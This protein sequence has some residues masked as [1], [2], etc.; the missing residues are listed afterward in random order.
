MFEQTIEKA[1]Q[2]KAE[3]DRKEIQPEDLTT[4][5]SHVVAAIT[6][7]L[8]PKIGD[9]VY[10]CLKP[11]T[12]QLNEIATKQQQTMYSLQAIEKQLASLI[13]Q[14][15][16]LENA[17]KENYHLSEQ[18]YLERII[19]PMIRLLFPAF[20]A[21]YDA[22]R[23][24]RKTGLTVERVA[25]GTLEQV[26]VH[27]KQFLL[28]YQIEPVKH[29]PGAEFDPRIMKPLKFV[30]TN[31]KEQNSRIAECLQIGFRQGKQR[32]MR[33]EGVSIFEYRPYEAG[34]VT[35]KKGDNHVNSD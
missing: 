33:Y 6:N 9:R 28:I 22:K 13:T 16:L 29:K 4:A 27:L 7:Q 18:H 25:N 26:C 2:G 17:S 32:I 11:L 5:L 12:S 21:I 15:K 31:K 34:S 24:G 35:D 8:V 1:N 14:N 30:P 19:E 20:D 3:T 23:R 10:E